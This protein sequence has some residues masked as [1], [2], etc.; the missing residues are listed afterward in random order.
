M[1]LNDVKLHI[2]VQYYK[3]DGKDISHISNLI[4]EFIRYSL[5]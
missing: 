4:K 3:V 2:I 5:V 1:S